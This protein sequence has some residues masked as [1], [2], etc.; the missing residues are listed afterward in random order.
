[1][2]CCLLTA[3]RV[4]IWNS[5]FVAQISSQLDCELISDRHEILDAAIPH[6]LA[7]CQALASNA[8]LCNNPAPFPLW[9]LMI[10]TVLKLVHFPHKL[11]G[12]QG[13]I[14]TSN[15]QMRK[16]KTP[17]LN[18]LSKLIQLKI[19][20]AELWIMVVVISDS[21]AALSMSPGIS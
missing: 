14:F 10:R 3:Y 15:L 9:H 2:K 11:W 20:R 7:R 16:Q 8:C 12:R 5:M 13:G 19:F 6:C 18:N 17:E 21:V 4:E 1:M